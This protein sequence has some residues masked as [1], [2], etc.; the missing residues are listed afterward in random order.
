MT[1]PEWKRDFSPKLVEYL[2]SLGG[3][4]K[5]RVSAAKLWKSGHFFCEGKPAC[6]I[7]HTEGWTGE[8]DERFQ[9]FNTNRAPSPLD[10]LYGEFDSLCQDFSLEAT[11]A[12]VKECIS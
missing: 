5:A 10:E 1:N 7:S 2:Q 6:L 12:A 11:V 9:S 8:G 4:A 3:E